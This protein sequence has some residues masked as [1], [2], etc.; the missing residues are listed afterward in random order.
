M[1]QQGWI[2]PVFAPLMMLGLIT[3]YVLA[4]I[5]PALA[6]NSQNESLTQSNR[7]FEQG[8]TAYQNGQMLEAIQ[9]WQNALTLYEIPLKRAQILGNLAIAY[10]ET[11][12][13]I[14]AL[15]VNQEALDIFDDLDMEEAVGQV[16][17]NLANVYVNLGDYNSAIAAYQTSLSAAQLSGDRVAEGIITGN[18]GYIYAI[19]GEQLIA[20]EKYEHSLAIA[21]EMNDLEGESHRLLNIGLAYHAL[22]NIPYAISY[23][24]MS[25]EIAQ[26]LNH[27][28]LQ[29]KAL[30]NLGMAIADNDQYD[31]A[32][33]H[34]E[35]SLTIAKTLHDPNLTAMILN[36]LGYTFLAANRLDEAEEKLREAISN[37]DS[38]RT[39]LNDT[40]NVS[41]FDTQ[42]YTYNLLAQILVAQNKPEA[43]LEISEAGRARAIAKLLTNRFQSTDI[44]LAGSASEHVDN[45]LP[46]TINE[47]RQLAQERNVTLIEY[48]L[49]PEEAFRQQGRQR[50]RISEIHI[51]VVKPTGEVKFNQVKLSPDE[52]SLQDLVSNSRRA[53]GVSDGRGGLVL[54][55]D[56][57]QNQLKTLHRLLI[58]P[59]AEWLPTN[60]ASP[61][62]IIPQERLFLVPFA[63]L[64][65]EAGEYL[66]E[67][68]TLLTA[69]SIRTLS[70]THAMRQNQ[71]ISVSQQ[72]L[73]EKEALVIGNPVMPNIWVSQEEPSKQLPT[74]PKA[75]NEAETIAGI[76]G[77]EPLIGHEATETFVKERI[78]TA[79]IVHLATHGLLEYGQPRTYGIQNIPGAVALAPSQDDDGLL[80]ANEIQAFELS[81]ELV[82]LSACDTGLG[83]ITGDGII[84]LSRSLIAAGAPSVVVSL[85]SVPDAPTADLMIKFYEELEL[86]KDK[87]QALRQAML[88]IMEEYPDEPQNWAAFT[89]IGEAN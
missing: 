88:Q 25:L 31:N 49:V 47:I 34:Y 79:Q 68:H 16:Q 7:A 48:S 58:E 29:A 61:V 9:H 60:P 35:Q 43:A 53:M 64:Q 6:Q 18:L 14:N 38:L 63:A 66:I 65:N 70:L 67:Q 42:I 39:Q 3:S 44:E 17:S 12:Q 84:G 21:R 26:D 71:R 85:W 23:Y 45:S 62:V 24:Q 83:T 27:R 80:T 50:G 56:L 5:P 4:T 40:Y 13:Y 75:V 36:N 10:Y 33:L 69:P 30:G 1:K 87:A 20:L 82:V 76:F 51:W 81:A 59:I 54:E 72:N 22:E 89:L 78:Q 73:T 19:Q 28:S 46:P 37:L 74:L 77:T 41:I 2:S 52:P 57:P 55:N 8:L 86:G 32:I 11:G 15:E